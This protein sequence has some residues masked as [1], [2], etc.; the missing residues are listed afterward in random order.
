MDRSSELYNIFT[1]QAKPTQNGHSPKVVLS[2]PFLE[3]FGVVNS[4]AATSINDSATHIKA[5]LRAI[6]DNHTVRE[7]EVGLLLV[8]AELASAS[9][10]SRA[11]L[12]LMEKAKTEVKKGKVNSDDA[13][14]TLELVS[15][16]IAATTTLAAMV[17]A[18]RLDLTICREAIE[19]HRKELQAPITI[20]AREGE[21]SHDNQPKHSERMAT[22]KAKPSGDMDA[23][24][25]HL[26]SAA[27]KALNTASTSRRAFEGATD[28]MAN[29][30]TSTMLSFARKTT[31]IARGS[32]PAATTQTN[33]TKKGYIF[34]V[35]EK[36][37]LERQRELMLLEER[38]SDS[39]AAKDIEATI[40]EL[41]R[42]TSIMQAKVS[43]QDEQLET[44][45]NDTQEAAANI[46]KATEELRK[47]V[48]QSWLASNQLTLLLWIATA[49]VLS[50]H[51][52]MS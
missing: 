31:T 41:S 45:E 43:E 30:V 21:V 38:A 8:D 3:A 32:E 7:A 35:E 52:I 11:L 10:A 23:L 39:A 14:A 50:A 18:R 4:A 26:K 46:G 51:T 17:D 29:T 15:H 12:A 47:P 27:A 24:Q 19:E 48:K 1:S 6:R 20:F 22:R 9:G 16:Y 40:G 42:L 5:A 13:G 37:E 28:K 34:S 2:D 36:A 49:F 25:G 44:L 33:D